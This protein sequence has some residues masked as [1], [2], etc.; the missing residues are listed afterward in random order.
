[1]QEKRKEVALLEASILQSL[2]RKQQGSGLFPTS[3][4][5]GAD[6]AMKLPT[7]NLTYLNIGSQASSGSHM[8][9]DELPAPSLLKTFEAN[10]ALSSVFG[11]ALP[12]SLSAGRDT[13]TPEQTRLRSVFEKQAHVEQGKATDPKHK[14]KVPH[15]KI[16]PSADLE[17]IVFQYRRDMT[18]CKRLREVPFKGVPLTAVFEHV[19]KELLDDMLEE[20]TQEIDTIFT[21]Y[22]EKFIGEI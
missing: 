3:H 9:P 11:I 6:T 8:G 22:A 5:G 17:D 20:I 16:R 12:S 21:D 10:D 7:R 15:T 19:S 13:K 14:P 18:R 4:T 1:M 2:S